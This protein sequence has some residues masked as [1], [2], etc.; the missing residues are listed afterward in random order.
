M[1]TATP[2]SAKAAEAARAR[3][4]ARRKLI[5]A[6]KAGRRQRQTS[7]SDDIQVNIVA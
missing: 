5:E 2:R 4:E 3:D 7:E 6:K 1:P